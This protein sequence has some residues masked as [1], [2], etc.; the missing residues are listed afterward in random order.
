MTSSELRLYHQRLPSICVFAALDARSIRTRVP[1]FRHG[2][3]PL[4]QERELMKRMFLAGVSALAVVAT[5]A[6]ANAA[7]LGRRREMPV[8]APIAVATSYNWTG[9]YVGI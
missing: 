8:K 5:L 4:L 7:D 1:A 3:G 9:F 2:V 6:T